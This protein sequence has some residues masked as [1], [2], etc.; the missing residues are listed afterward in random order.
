METRTM[1]G[2]GRA[3]PD[4]DVRERIDA[5]M[6]RLEAHEQERA[7]LAEELHDGPAQ[8]LANAIFQTELVERALQ[9]D[10][11]AATAEINRLRQMLQRE[12]ETLRAYI[13]QMRPQLHE[14]DA[15]EQALQDAAATLT[16]YTGIP[17]D[18]RL[19][20]A[21]KELEVGA[22]NVVLRVAQEALRNIGKHSAAQRAWVSTQ[23]IE[24]DGRGLWELEVGDD[25]RGIDN[26]VADAGL[27]RRHFCLRFMRERSDLL[28]AQLSIEP[29]PAAVGTV[30]RLRIDTS[31]ERS[32]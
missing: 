10:P 12:L 21:G 19:H 1:D 30:V 7:R 13:S 3:E 5:S 29:G 27:R 17:V 9:A 16:E 23:H 24:Q 20:A 18:V 32:Q 14:P 11:A 22:R 2:R 6:A 31:G 28:G 26:S 8:A 25:G 15:L 4:V